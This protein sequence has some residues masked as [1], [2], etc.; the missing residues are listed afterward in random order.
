MELKDMPDL[1]VTSLAGHIEKCFSEAVQAKQDVTERL[2]ACERQRRGE[3][4]PRMKAEI[5]QAGMQEIFMMV[6]DI[7]CRAADSWIKDVMMNH[8]NSTWALTTTQE[9]TL[10]PEVTAE[11]AEVV[12]QEAVA[13]AAAGMPVDPEAMELRQAEILEEAEKRVKEM[14][15]QRCRKMENRIVDKL[16][17]GGWRNAL[18]ELVYDFTTFPAAFLKG[19]VLRK[20]KVMKWGAAFTPEIAEG[21][22]LNVDRVSPYDIF[23]SPGAVDI[24]DGYLIQRHRLGR[25]ALRQM[26]DLKGADPEAISRVLNTYKTGYRLNIN[27]DSEREDLAQRNRTFGADGLIEALEY[28]GPSSGQ[29]LKEWGIVSIDGTKIDPDDEYQINAWKIGGEVIRVVLNPD[30]LDRRPYSKASFEEIP[31]QFWGLSLPEMMADVQTIC[32]ASARSL[33]YNMAM[34]A[35][36]QAEISVDRLPPGAPIT[37]FFPGKI[38]QTTTDRT[39]GGQ[40]A[41][42]FFQPSMNAESLLNIYN[43]FN[44]VADEV[45]GVPN[46]VYGS[47]NVAGAGRTA[48]G[49]SMLMENAAKGIKHAIMN[50]DK[51]T[52]NVIE[53]IYNHLMI[54]DPDTA[55]KGDMQIVAAGAIGAMVREQQLQ[56]RKEFMAQVLNPVDAQLI[57]PLGRAYMIRETAKE[58]WPDINK[59]IPDPEKLAKQMQAM[60]MAQAQQAQAQQAQGGEGGPPAAPPVQGVAG[61]PP[62]AMADG[63][64]VGG[65]QQFMD[66]NQLKSLQSQLDSVNSQIAQLERGQ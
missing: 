11:A 46:Y 16:Q 25:K 17:E 34:A 44:R 63:G 12:M 29:M 41:V 45:T 60:Q 26:K 15:D 27:G 4:S 35:G 48:S 23:P 55:I 53:R 50:L 40:P 31:G 36:P 61:Q 18:A 1:A 3:Y 13:V 57:G 32:N 5:A 54:H 6:T 2:L 9:P 51:A 49:L 20:K 47:T 22:V 10:P 30:P 7:K 21:I 64:T 42:R 24:Q 33:V 19:P 38:W 28:W 65:N 58:L 52:S 66:D 37:K 62:Q 56:A 59:I 14:A 43:H 39:G 8:D